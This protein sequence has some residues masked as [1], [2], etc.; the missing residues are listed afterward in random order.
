MADRSA[1]TVV[2]NGCNIA[3]MRGGSGPPLVVLHGAS[4]GGTW[5]PFMAKLAETYN[6][7]ML[8][9]A[10]LNKSE[11]RQLIY[12]VGGSIGYVGQARSV[13]LVVQDP[14]SPDRRIIGR[15]KGN[16][17]RR[18]P[19]LAYQIVSHDDWS[20]LYWEAGASKVTVDSIINVGGDDE[21]TR[22][23]RVDATDF[24][25]EALKDGPVAA[26]EIMNLIIW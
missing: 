16:L 24:L 2:I 26:T 10:H 12:R 13:L 1:S 6:V 7:A 19:D 22:A 3:L 20:S 14:A 25:E 18:P 21:N 17:G 23:D 11:Q 4:G 8:G 9:L 15:I 5:L